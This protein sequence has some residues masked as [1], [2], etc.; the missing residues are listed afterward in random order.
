MERRD[1]CPG[2]RGCRDVQ[3]AHE[4][5]VPGDRQGRRMRDMH[6]GLPGRQ[7]E[8]SVLRAC[9]KGIIK[10]VIK[11]LLIIYYKTIYKRRMALYNEP[12]L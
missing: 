8:I 10:I 6:G 4:E 12:K 9:S 2:D 11:K 1:R 3:Q 7:K 5:G